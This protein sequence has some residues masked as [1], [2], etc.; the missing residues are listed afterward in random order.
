MSD[1]NF[2][3]ERKTYLVKHSRD[4]SNINEVKV[5]IAIYIYHVHNIAKIPIILHL[6]IYVPQSAVCE[7]GR[8][9]YDDF[10]T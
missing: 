5:C 3:P 8:I 4:V 2:L 6:Y 7:G 10:A 1:V 9:I